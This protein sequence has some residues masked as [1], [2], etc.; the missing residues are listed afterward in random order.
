M[1]AGDQFQRI[2]QAII[3][4]PQQARPQRYGEHLS[5]LLNRITDGHTT[6]GLK[7]LHISF[8][9]AHPKHFGLQLF[10]TASLTPLR[11]DQYHFVFGQRVKL[12]LCITQHADTDNIIMHAGHTCGHGI[13]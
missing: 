2:L 5:G 13:R 1:L 10:R 6:R 7:H 3:N 8:A 12:T 11:T 9:M 4:L